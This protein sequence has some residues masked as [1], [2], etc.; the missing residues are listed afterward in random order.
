MP[1]SQTTDFWQ[2]PAFSREMTEAWNSVDAVDIGSFARTPRI[3][4]F[5]M[6]PGFLTEPRW[7]GGLDDPADVGRSDANPKGIALSVGDDNPFFDPRRPGD[8]GGV[9]YYRLHTQVQLVDW[10][11]TSVCFGLQAWAPAGLECGGV[12]DG[13]TVIAPGVG[14][15][16]DL[17]DGSGLHGFV[18]QNF[19]GR[20]HDGPLRC[21]MAWHCPI[22]PWDE[23]SDSGMFFFVQA[24]AR[25]DFS[26][27]RQGRPMNW[28][29]VPGLHWRVTEAFWMSIGASRSGMVT[30]GWQF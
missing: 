24:H 19:H 4:L 9:G 5:R 6:L 20:N 11:P 18:G 27:D 25:Y 1:I 23:I 12:Q 15:F 8:P 16:H 30:C 13:P 10:G 29:L 22:T 2:Q 3:P 21:G 28:E 17:G 14:I 7:L 26:G